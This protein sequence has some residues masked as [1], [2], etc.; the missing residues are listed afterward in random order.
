LLVLGLFSPLE[1]TFLKAPVDA[2]GQVVRDLGEEKTQNLGEGES[3]G[4]STYTNGN[5]NDLLETD[6]SE[7]SINNIRWETEDCSDQSSATIR[8]NRVPPE[9]T[10]LTDLGGTRIL[11]IKSSDEEERFTSGVDLVVDRTLGEDRSLTLGHGVKDESGAALFDE[12]GFHGSRVHN[13]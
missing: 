4:C 12:S 9:L 10:S 11:I 5:V 3:D 6:V 7:S 2:N 1:A 13:V 8:Y